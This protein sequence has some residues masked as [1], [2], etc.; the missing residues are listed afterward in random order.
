MRSDHPS[1]PRPR[2]LGACASALRRIAAALARVGRRAQARGLDQTL[3]RRQVTWHS[4]VQELPQTA[5]SALS[6][7]GACETVL[8]LL[9]V[10]R[11]RFPCDSLTAALEATFA[12][13]RVDVDAT[14]EHAAAAVARG[15]RDASSLDSMA[16]A[17]ARVGLSNE[18][19]A[20]A[21]PAIAAVDGRNLRI[22]RAYWSL[23]LGDLERAQEGFGADS[24][25]WA[26]GSAPSRWGEASSPRP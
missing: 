6:R 4:G 5:R 24:R 22:D 1:P 26:L 16:G 11:E 14:C 12:A 15:G 19:D 7:L 17:Y 8:E 20:T 25:E 13:T 18:P 3:V 10:L 9:E 21:Q 23:Q 2:G